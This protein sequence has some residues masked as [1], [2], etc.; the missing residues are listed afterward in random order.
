MGP[1]VSLQALTDAG[2][3][4][5]YHALRLER[6]TE[7]WVA[8]GLS[9]RNEVSAAVSADAACVELVGSSSVVGL[10]AKPI[11]DLAI[12]LSA[13][14]DMEVVRRTLEAAGWIYRGDAGEHGGHVFVL[15]ARLGHRVAHLH[16][17]P[18]GGKQWS[19]YL[20]LRDL[21]RRSPA[22]RQRYEDVK[23][24]LAAT[25]V[26]DREAYTKGKTAIVGA[27]LHEADG[28]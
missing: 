14:H 6:T 15:E 18:H 16:M 17:V 19:D 23:V 28:S 3:G 10:L 13:D 12:G 27:L 4:L 25:Y 1:P 5:D 8:A 11:V 7:S 26:D 2:L 22:A 24:E 21:L 20:S 9:L